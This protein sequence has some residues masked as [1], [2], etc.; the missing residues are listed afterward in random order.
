MTFRQLRRP[1]AE[2]RANL[3]QIA[4][5]SSGSVPLVQFVDSLFACYRNNNAMASAGSPIAIKVSSFI[6]NKTGQSID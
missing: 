2:L 4:F 3:F 5:K 6:Q 1:W